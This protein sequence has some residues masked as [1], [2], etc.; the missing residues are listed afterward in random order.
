MKKLSFLVFLILIIMNAQ[1]KRAILIFL[2]LDPIKNTSA[3]MV[4]I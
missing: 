2:I 1:Q 3:S 4:L